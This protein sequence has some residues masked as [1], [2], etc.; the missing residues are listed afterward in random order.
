MPRGIAV[1][2]HSATRL[3]RLAPYL[4]MAPAVAILLVALVW[5]LLYSV[6]LS[7][8][9]WKLGMPIDAAEF[10]GLQNYRI[11]LSDPDTWVSLRVT[12]IFAFA[13]VF[14]EMT[15][16]VALAL[17]LDRSIRGMSA[18]R[19]AFIMPMM[20]APIVV[21]LMW[22]YIYDQQ[23]GPLAQLFR[24]FGFES[25]QWLTSPHMALPSVII[26]DVWQWTPFI[27]I[28]AL[29]ALQGLP[30]PVIEAARVDGASTLQTVFLVKLPLILPVIIVAALLRLIDAFKVLEVIF[31]MTGGGPGL[32]TEIMSMRIYKTAFEF[33]QL[34][35]ASAL[36]NLLL[37][38]VAIISVVF[39]VFNKAR[40]KT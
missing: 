13:V 27:F 34:G 8:H 9:E 32:A 1:L 14:F 26:A 3:N 25:P 5:P 7:F 11:L 23:F 18:L 24:A 29:A 2:A 31:I 22:R 39:V 16:G 21:G 35:R 28:L 10:N 6:W 30:K 37:L 19:T 17:M 38:V 33:Q 36:S 15:L 40:N 20:V 12:L 4:F